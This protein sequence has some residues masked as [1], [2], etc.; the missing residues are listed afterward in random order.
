[1]EIVDK[2]V[3]DDNKQVK[4]FLERNNLQITET[5]NKNV[6][7]CE[8][9][10]NKLVIVKK[11]NNFPIDDYHF[12][13]DEIYANKQLQHKNIVRMLG[14]FPDISYHFI[15][16]EYINGRDLYDFFTK[17]NYK[18]IKEN[19][20]KKIF[21]QAFNAIL[22]CHTH[23]I[24]HRDI[25]LENFVIDLNGNLKLIDFG[26]CCIVKLSCCE[27]QDRHCGSQDY[28]SP[29]IIL[30][31]NYPACSCDTWALGTTLYALKFGQLPFAWSQR[32][33]IKTVEDHPS[34]EITH[35]ISSN[36]LDLI[37]KM[38]EKTHTKRIHF[39]DIKNHPWMKISPFEFI[40]LKLF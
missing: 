6:Y 38:L 10:D 9:K 33:S 31:E 2:S 25:K 21:I 32:K 27:L 13:L 15:V 36:L 39:S 1:M 22:F 35:S 26:L 37:S 20:L 12:P 8:N 16:L 17:R 40:K 14:Y 34:F 19:E 3:P 30:R 18:P 23:K 4:I 29:D 24:I 5:I 11:I 7:I 28:I